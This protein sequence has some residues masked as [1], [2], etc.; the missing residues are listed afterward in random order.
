MKQCPKCELNW[1]KDDEEMCEVCYNN[2]HKTT[3]IHKGRTAFA[4]ETFTFINEPKRF[5]GKDGYIAINSKGER[6][7]II[8]CTDDERTPAF[9][10]CELCFFEDYQSKYG[11]WHRFTSNG[12]RIKWSFLCDVLKKEGKYSCLVD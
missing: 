4:H 10:H 8:I 9:N 7:G 6:V 3:Q 2:L 1:I 12:E 5:R 11:E